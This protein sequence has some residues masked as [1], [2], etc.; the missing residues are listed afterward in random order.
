MPEENQEGASGP[1]H[2]DWLPWLIP[3]ILVPLIFL[4]TPL[5]AILIGASLSLILNRPLIG[6]GNKVSTLALQSAIVLLGFTLDVLNLWEISQDFAG[7]IAVYVL[8][9]LVAGIVLGKLLRVD[10]VLTQL[11]AVGTSICGGTAIAALGPV[12]KARADQIALALTI[13]FFLNM[14]AILAFPLIGNWLGMSQAQFGMW[15]AL[16]IHD[17]S[18]VLAA[19]DIY[20]Q[21]AVEVAATLK[22][23]R[24]LWLI[25]LI[26][27]FNI[28]SSTEMT[29]IRLPGFVA[30]F[31]L[32]SILGSVLRSY[33][34]TP[35][36]LFEVAQQLS[37]ALIISALFFIGLECTRETTKKLRGRVIWLAV[38]L[39]AGVVPVTLLISLNH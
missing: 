29:R 15:A 34:A 11:I 37:K 13:V 19:A 17:T 22:L 31:V 36:I 9:S 20:G 33:V 4:G 1:N 2:F 38:L 10:S 35:D 27:G 30:A 7:I 32:A 3:L 16:A 5:L 28:L 24:T 18:S 23:G 8:V 39:W 12:L 25:P 21:R 26:L 14:I 6:D